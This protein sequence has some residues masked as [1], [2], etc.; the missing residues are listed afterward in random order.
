MFF[1]IEG[2]F[3]KAIFV[4]NYCMLPA[5]SFKDLIVWQKS[6]KY[7]LEVYDYTSKFPKHELFSLTNQFRRAAVSIA[8]NIAEGFRKK[9]IREKIRF[10][11]ISQGSLEECRYFEILS[12]D[13]KYGDARHLTDILEATSRL[14]NSYQRSLMNHEN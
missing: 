12:Q 5:Q 14:L 2:F 9:S 6:H 4:A 10:F 1:H 13:L 7:V 8:A 11:N 3:F